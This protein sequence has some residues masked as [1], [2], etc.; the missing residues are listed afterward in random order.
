MHSKA[1][2]K[3]HGS[4]YISVVVTVVSALLDSPPTPDELSDPNLTLTRDLNYHGQADNAPEIATAL[5][6]N[7]TH[8]SASQDLK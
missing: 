7:L 6:L 2:K 3:S 8:A 1:P 4:S 5:N